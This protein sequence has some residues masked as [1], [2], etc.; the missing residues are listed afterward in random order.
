MI[1]AATKNDKK[2][3]SGVIQFVLLRQ[4]G[5]AYIERKVSD[6]EILKTLQWLLGGSYE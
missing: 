4:I 2:M 1:L 6:T 3:D 5:N